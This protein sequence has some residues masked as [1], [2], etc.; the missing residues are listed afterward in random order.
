M[1][2]KSHTFCI[3]THNIAVQLVMYPHLIQ[4]ASALRAIYPVVLLSEGKD[5]CK[6]SKVIESCTVTHYVMHLKYRAIS[7]V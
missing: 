1:Y 2:S 7:G 6:A 3:T 5:S 4:V